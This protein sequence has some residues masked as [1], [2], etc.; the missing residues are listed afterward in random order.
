M[1]PLLLNGKLVSSQIS[2]LAK[3][4][5]QLCIVA[6]LPH[7]RYLFLMMGHSWPLHLYF[8]HSYYFDNMVDIIL[9]MTGFDIS[10]ISLVAEATCSTN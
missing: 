2:L 3:K 1:N 8:R 7:Q 6:Q 10:G 5:I 4:I 9:R